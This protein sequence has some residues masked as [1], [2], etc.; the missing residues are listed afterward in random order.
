[1]PILFALT[2]SCINDNY[3][4]I[5]DACTVKSCSGGFV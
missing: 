1:M 2:Q 3:A 5:N 4:L